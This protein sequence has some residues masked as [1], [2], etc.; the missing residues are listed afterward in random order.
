MKDDN[1]LVLMNTAHQKI[2][3]AKS[4]PEV[5]DIHDKA[6]TLQEYAKQQK[7]GL[8]MQND[9]A[10]IVIRAERKA[11]ELLKETELDKGGRPTE[12]NQSNDSTSLPKLKDLGI[13]KFE[14]SSW[15]RIAE[16][17]EDDFEQ[18]I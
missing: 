6:K 9:L 4:L 16:I 2:Q 18:H 1:A 15:Q 11:G 13:S 5:K 14:S 7:L 10:E 3:L 8:E 12:D 17:P